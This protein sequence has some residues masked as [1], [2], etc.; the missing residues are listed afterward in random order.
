M[1]KNKEQ[2]LINNPSLVIDVPRLLK[3]HK[4]GLSIS[5]DHSVDVIS[6]NQLEQQILHDTSLDTQT[7]QN[8]KSVISYVDN[9]AKYMSNAERKNLTISQYL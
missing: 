2:D 9:Q 7:K 4:K 8:L 6:L 1:L 3:S 5:L